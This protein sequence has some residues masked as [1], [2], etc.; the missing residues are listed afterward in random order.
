MTTQHHL[1]GLCFNQK[2]FCPLEGGRGAEIV[3]QSTQDYIGLIRNELTIQNPEHLITERPT[4]IRTVQLLMQSF[5]ILCF[6]IKT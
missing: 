4:L 5:G 1:F 6:P 3:M 2:T